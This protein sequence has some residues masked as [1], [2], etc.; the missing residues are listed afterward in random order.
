LGSFAQFMHVFPSRWVRFAEL[1]LAALVQ[2]RFIQR[3]PANRA[4]NFVRKD[5]RLDQL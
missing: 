3:D 1:A 2:L 4:N 5:L